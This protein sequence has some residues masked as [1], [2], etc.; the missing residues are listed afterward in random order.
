MTERITE[1]VSSAHA[2]TEKAGLLETTTLRGGALLALGGHG[3]RGSR[4]SIS[5]A[6]TACRRA[7]IVAARSQ[8]EAMLAGGAETA[9]IQPPFFRDYGANIQL[10][11][12]NPCR[13]IRPI[14]E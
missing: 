12:G 14:S 4:R 13:V 3:P 2:G 5:L 6:S 8:R 11:T 1:V 9:W 7:A 10:G